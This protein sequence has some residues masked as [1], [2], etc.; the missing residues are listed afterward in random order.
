MLW[1]LEFFRDQS[2][3]LYFCLLSMTSVSVHEGPMYRNTTISKYVLTHLKHRPN[4]F[5]NSLNPT[6]QYH[7]NVMVGDAEIWSCIIC[8]L[9]WSYCCLI[10]I[11]SSCVAFHLYQSLDLLFLACYIYV[12][13]L[14]IYIF[15]MHSLF[16]WGGGGRGGWDKKVIKLNTI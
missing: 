7:N 6:K 9:F 12:F 14:S 1:S 10:V 15:H 5:S 2:L 3:V 16:F 11:F 13:Y 4:D 8:S